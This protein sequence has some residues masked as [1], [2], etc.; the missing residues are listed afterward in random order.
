MELKIEKSFDGN[1]IMII[2][3]H[4]MDSIGVFLHA[5]VSGGSEEMIKVVKFGGSSCK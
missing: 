5:K 4:Y 3:I 1:C 2:Y